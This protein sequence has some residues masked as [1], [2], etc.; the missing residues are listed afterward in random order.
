MDPRDS[1]ITAVTLGCFDL[2]HVGHVSFLAKCKEFLN[3]ISRSNRLIVLLS[4]DTSIRSSKG[5]DRP[6]YPERD[7]E[8]LLEHITTVDEVKIVT[9]E[10]T[11]QEYMYEIA[12]SFFFKGSDTKLDCKHLAEEVQLCAKNGTHTVL[13]SVNDT[14][15]TSEIIQRIK[16]NGSN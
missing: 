10:N 15:H 13:I 12:P 4:S 5:N 6:I 16:S 2:L 14:I 7:R 1:T 3:S 9:V 8:Y 11:F